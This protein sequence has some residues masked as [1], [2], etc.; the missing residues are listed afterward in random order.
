MQ[1]SVITRTPIPRHRPVPTHRRD[2]AVY[3]I[4][5]FCGV[6]IL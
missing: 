2:I 1:I 5:N 6:E 4:C 3:P